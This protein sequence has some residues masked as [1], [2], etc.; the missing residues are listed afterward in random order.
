MRLFPS[1]GRKYLLVL[2]YQPV[3]D[4]YKIYDA[5]DITDGTIRAVRQ[6]NQYVAHEG[7]S[8]LNGLPAWQLD[9]VLP[10]LLN[11]HN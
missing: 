10:K 1:A 2:S 5:W 3:G 11:D 7:K 6:R 8:A 9:V 4:F